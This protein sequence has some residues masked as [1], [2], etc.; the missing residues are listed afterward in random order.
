M[1]ANYNRILA[2]GLSCSVISPVADADERI[3]PPWLHEVK[4]GVLHHDTGGLWSGFR[5]ESGVDVNLEAIFS[6]HVQV[7]GGFIRPAFGGSVNTAGDT[8]KLYSGIRW[9]YDHASGIFAGVGVGGAIHNGKLHLQEND[10][11]ALGSRILFHIPIEIG[12]RSTAK[13]RCRF[14]SIMFPMPSSQMKTKEW[15]PWACDTAIDSKPAD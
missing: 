12:Y 7:L 11:K 15:I 1:Q 3:I 8:S 2:I 5:R 10:R 9:Q 13:M 4:I 6:P 14:I